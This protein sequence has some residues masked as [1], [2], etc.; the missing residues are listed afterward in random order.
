M[1]AGSNVELGLFIR[2]YHTIAISVSIVSGTTESGQVVI[3][4]TDGI[5]VSRSNTLTISSGSS[6]TVFMGGLSPGTEYIIKF[7]SDT[8]GEYSLSILVTSTLGYNKL[9]GSVSG[10]S[11]LVTSLYGSMNNQSVMINKLYGSAPI[12]DMTSL[13]GEI[14]AGGAG[15]ITAFNS[16]A[17]MNTIS[18]DAEIMEKIEMSGFDDFSI[19]F[20]Y[21]LDYQDWWAWL[22]S[23]NFTFELSSTVYGPYT[24][25]ELGITINPTVSGTDYIDITVT[26]GMV[27]KTS[28]IHQGFG[29]YEEKWG[30]VYYKNDPSDT[31]A[32]VIS[33]QSQAE[34]ES[35]C[36]Q[37]NWTATIGGGA[38]TVTNYTPNTPNVIVG[39]DIGKSIKTIPNNF[40]AGCFYL[41]HPLLL[42]SSLESIG[43]GFLQHTSR[44]LSVIDV[45]ELPA[46]IIA[47][48]GASFSQL[49]DS[50]PAY[51]TGMTIAGSNRAAWLAKF[52]NSTTTPYRKLLDAGY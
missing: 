11:A 44:M 42:P 32:L 39:I 45:G 16:E 10:D 26:T 50:V 19:E 23:E 13:E 7:Y 8:A 47:S 1:A 3:F 17:F 18:H 51:T 46:S 36:G 27:N 15:N 24:L 41:D 20:Y 33:L 49:L 37:G 5:D 6:T 4:D 9:Y 38:V 22:D 14:R 12:K 30:R 34:F 48:D 31:R 35:L 2:Q 21:G 43:T 25:N 40:L 29:H 28:L 52:P